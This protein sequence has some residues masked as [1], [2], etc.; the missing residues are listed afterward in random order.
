[1]SS[2]DNAAVAVPLVVY[3]LAVPL[4]GPSFIVITQVSLGA[5]GL[6]GMVAAFGTTIGVTVYATA[7]LLGIS[8]LA[9]ALPWLIT[10]I[11]ILGGIYLIYLGTLA[12]RAAVSGGKGFTTA[13]R[14][15][16]ECPSLTRTFS[17]GL[18]VSL[19][20]PKMAAFFFGLFAPVVSPSYSPDARLFVLCGVVLI[21]LLYHQALATLLVLVAASRPVKRTQRW[22]DAFVGSLMTTFGIGLLVEAVRSR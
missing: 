8:T 19:G 21:D 17:K 10:V 22:L 6:P 12:L 11:Q 20:N 7:T 14:L 1:M 2:L 9:A 18:L 15:P 3:A 16:G 5:G 13:R 4:P